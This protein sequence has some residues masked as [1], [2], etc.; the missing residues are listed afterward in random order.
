MPKASTTTT[1]ATR[2]V[3]PRPPARRKQEDRSRETRDK[4]MQAAIDVL[5]RDG[6]NRL[7]MKE[8]VKV[9]GVSSGALMH[10]F[11]SKAE[12]V[13]AATAMVYD[14][15]I[16]RGQRVALT[17]E[18]HRNP[19]EGYI[20]DCTSVY[21]DWPFLAALETIVVARTDPELMEKILPVMEHYRSTC[22]VIWLAVFQKAGLTEGRAKAVL[23]LTLNLVRGMAINSIWRHDEAHYRQYLKT[24]IAM[25]SHEFQLPAHV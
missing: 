13:V 25:A 19:I 16:A 8:V 6:Y 24:W 3:A 7:T 9:A 2:G 23:N 15:A 10:H 5:L 22:D 20:A 17:A 12:L 14:E 21:F 11:T 1:S 18:A 4:L